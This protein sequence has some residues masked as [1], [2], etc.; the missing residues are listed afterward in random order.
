MFALR[1]HRFPSLGYKT[2]LLAANATFLIYC[3][4]MIKMLI[5]LI[6]Q[7]FILI[8][9]IQDLDGT[10]AEVHYFCVFTMPFSQHHAEVSWGRASLQ[11]GLVLD[12]SPLPSPRPSAPGTRLLL[13]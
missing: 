3:L 13:M 10:N 12:T 9:V 1:I 7:V 2:S 4:F 8:A 5:Y 11:I 6:T